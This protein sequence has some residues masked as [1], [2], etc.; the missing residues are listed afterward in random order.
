MQLIVNQGEV[1]VPATDIVIVFF[2]Y[3]FIVSLITCKDKTYFRHVDL[4][5]FLRS[6]NYFHAIFILQTHLML[7]FSSKTEQNL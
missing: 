7:S 4:L 2:F 6:D 3:L 5:L 1:Y